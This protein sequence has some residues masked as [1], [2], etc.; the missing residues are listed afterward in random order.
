M[1]HINK[2]V[3]PGLLSCALLFGIE[4]SA[5]DKYKTDPDPP[6]NWHSMDL[7]TDGYYGISLPQAYSFLKGKKK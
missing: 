1:Y 6:K 3:V 7:K 2:W 4:A 5:Q